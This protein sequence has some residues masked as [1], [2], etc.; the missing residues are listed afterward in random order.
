MSD[1]NGERAFWMCQT[2]MVKRFLHFTET[3]DILAVGTKN[4]PVTLFGICTGSASEFAGRAWRGGR[5]WAVVAVVGPRDA[6]G[7]TSTRRGTVF[8]L[9]LNA[10][11]T[12][13]PTVLTLT[14]L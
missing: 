1:F 13:G 12:L 3:H 9:E 2:S 10:F 6:S 8:C 14:G 7:V 4:T 5:L 11:D